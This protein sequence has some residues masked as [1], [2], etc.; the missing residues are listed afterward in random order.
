[1]SLDSP[2]TYL[3]GFPF[4]YGSELVFPLTLAYKDTHHFIKNGVLEI[5]GRKTLSRCVYSF[6][7]KT[8]DGYDWF[9]SLQFPLRGARL[10]NV[11]FPWTQDWGN[12]ES[13]LDRAVGVF[14]DGSVHQDSVKS[15]VNS[16][17]GA[18]RSYTM[19]SI[20]RRVVF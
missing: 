5:A 11:L 14:G 1:M 19:K 3:K 13:Q 20:S 8:Q 7:E 16:L 12:S 17:A 9:A 18:L 2:Q 4:Q 15:L 6:G 10:I